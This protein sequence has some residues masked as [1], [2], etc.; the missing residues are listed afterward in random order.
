MS[1]SITILGSGGAVPTST[2]NPTSQLIECNGRHFLID[3]G[4]GTQMQT[5]K[6]GVNLQRIDIVFISHLHGDHY[7]GLVGLLSTMHMMGRTKSIAIHGPIGLKAIIDIQLHAAGSR[8]AFDVDVLEVENGSSGILYED[9]KVSVSHFPLAHK[10]PTSGFIVRQKVRDRTLLIEKAQADKVKVEYFHLLKKSEDVTDLNGNI[11]RYMD[12]TSAPPLPMSYAYC[13]DTKYH[14]PIIEFI[15]DVNVLYH[16]ATFTELLADRA[17][18]TKHST[19]SQAATIA[20]KANVES[21]LMG[22]LSAR[23]TDGAQHELEARLIFINS[24]F[25]DDGEIIRIEG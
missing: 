1:F 17:K 15:K 5:R 8:L 23:Y 7:F 11:I 24:R 9:N 22:H 4:E 6:Y 16:E 12:Y 25:V 3:C 10:V 18:T 21:L 13:S 19:A 14:E 2:R 20:K